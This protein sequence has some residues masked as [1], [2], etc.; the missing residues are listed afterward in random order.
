LLFGWRVAYRLAGLLSD[1]LIC[2]SIVVR[3]LAIKAGCLPEKTVVI[4]N[5]FEHANRETPLG[6]CPCYGNRIDQLQPII[7]CVSAI[8]PRKG[9][10][11][12]FRAFSIVR[13]EIPSAQLYIY[14]DGKARYIRALKTLATRLNITGATHFM[15][16]SGETGAPYR[17][18]TLFVL[19]SY[20]EAFG[21]VY[22]EAGLSGIPAIG[23]SHGGAPE[24]IEDGVT[25]LIVPPED[26]EELAAAM[27]RI[28]KDKLLATQM[29]VRAQERMNK[30]FDLR[31]M[32]CRVESVYEALLTNRL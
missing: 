28:L 12:L 24:I 2:N 9:H 15:G 22:V 11:T 31:E 6:R 14:G 7:G 1:K 20:A 5:G 16:K 10:K 18:F 8:H 27:L 17:A 26:P 3:N 23:T 19:P 25:G 30:L 21:R 4:Y 29:G 13:R 32:I